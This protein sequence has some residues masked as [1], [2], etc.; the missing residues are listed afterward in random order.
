MGEIS[1]TYLLSY[2]WG[3]RQLA[4][5]TGGRR[6]LRRACGGARQRIEL[7]ENCW[8]DRTCESIWPGI[9]QW[10]PWP[11]RMRRARNSWREK[12][13]KPRL[14]R[15]AGPRGPDRFFH[16]LHFDWAVGG[17]FVLEVRH[18]QAPAGR[19]VST[20]HRSQCARHL[21]FTNHTLTAKPNAFRLLGLAAVRGFRKPGGQ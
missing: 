17:S 10:R 2:L 13:Q 15:A 6:S 19:T 18:Q 9:P 5:W 4:Y 12:C 21:Y 11:H 14:E 20:G 3:D 1:S 7:S 8:T 16:R